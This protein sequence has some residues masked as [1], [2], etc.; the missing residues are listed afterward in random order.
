M[1]EVL[2]QVLLLVTGGAGAVGLVL[3]FIYLTPEKAEKWFAIVTKLLITVGIGR[4]K[5][6][7][8]WIRHDIQGRVNEFV[9]QECSSLPGT[10]ADRVKL[11][12]VDGSITKRALLDGDTVV[13]RVRREDPREENFCHAVCLFVSQSLLFKA[14]RYISPPQGE[15]VDLLVSK[16]LLERQKPAVVDHFVA[17]YLQPAID[18]D[19]RTATLF[20]DLVRLDDGALF[21]PIY[22]QELKFLGQKVFGGRKDAA[23]IQ[24]VTDLVGFLKEFVDRAVGE[25]A[26]DLN[27]TRMYSRF[28]IVIIGKARK[29]RHESVGPYV[30]Y[31]RRELTQARTESIYLLAPAQNRPYVEEVAKQVDPEYEAY[32]ETSF[33]RQLRTRGGRTF[34]AEQFL[35]ILRA[36][37]RQVYIPRK[38]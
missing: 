12:W 27:F 15:S 35:M 36:R 3:L 14:K 4:R 38:P 6:H 9:R 30:N 26:V 22:L 21:F 1:T 28:A 33:K 11:E 2:G 20:D 10:V 7:K 18:K 19:G 16:R 34:E 24:D 23:I 5:L 37:D 29:L 32:A 13:V 25:E 31:I 17:N 8:E